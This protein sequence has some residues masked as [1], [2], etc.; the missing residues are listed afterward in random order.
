MIL[1][2]LFVSI[3]LP[4]APLPPSG[5]ILK[6]DLRVYATP[7]VVRDEAG[8]IRGEGRY[9]ILA[10]GERCHEG[11]WWKIPPGYWLC[12]GWFVPGND[13]PGRLENWS[14]RNPVSGWVSGK[15]THS[16]VAATMAR[17]LGG[18][19]RRMRMLRGFLPVD[20]V[21]VAGRPMHRLYESGYIATQSVE[22]F[23]ASRLTSVG[24][25]AADL[26]LGFVVTRDASTWRRIGGKWEKKEAV[27]R[28]SVRSLAAAEDGHVWVKK[29]N[30]ALR[31]SDLRIA[32]A[33]PPPPAEV[34]GADEPWVDV[35]LK[36]QILFA[37]RGKAVVRVFLIAAAAETPAGV[38]RVYWKLVNQTFD[39]QRDRNAYYLEAV[40]YV[41]YF[42]DAYALHG[43]YW[44]DAFGTAETHGCV[45]LTPAD[46]R[47]LFDFLGPALPD[48]YISIRPVPNTTGGV[49]RLRR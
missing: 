41:I 43:A 42:K 19:H 6:G 39:R 13:A 16:Y 49:I 5:H 11:F 46:A 26:P 33:P 21:L 36:N 27:A 23:P 37:L 17:A 2:S 18:S 48:G 47:W 38:H 24:V 20:Q 1:W 29:D 31:E 30:V 25:T 9:A 22:P 15:G 44:H 7:A 8:K 14:A 3:F 10:R 34:K 40:P 32:V 45:N 4:S 35:D 28:Y 12:S